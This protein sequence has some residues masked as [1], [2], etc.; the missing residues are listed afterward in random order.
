MLNREQ[1][2][3]AIEYREKTNKFMT[4]N[5]IHVK[6]AG[7]QY[8]VISAVVDE[9]LLNSNGTAHGGL[10]VTMADVALGTACMYLGEKTVTSDISYRYLSAA[11]V[12]DLIT[13]KANVVKEGKKMIVAE[14]KL[15]VGD[16][17]IGTAD[18]TMFRIGETIDFAEELAKLG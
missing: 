6:D 17:L 4:K 11:K 5:G 8:S 13:A 15:Y 2:A 14:V 12:G 10:L 9:S 1:M 7:Y 16:R 3:K 18:G